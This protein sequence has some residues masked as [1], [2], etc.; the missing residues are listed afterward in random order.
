MFLA[1]I[2]T[3]RLLLWSES[4]LFAPLIALPFLLKAKMKKMG[5]TL[6]SGEVVTYPESPF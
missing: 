2:A 1:I 3:M 4:W 5:L 6:F